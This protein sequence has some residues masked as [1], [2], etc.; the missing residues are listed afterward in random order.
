MQ[1]NSAGRGGRRG[2]ESPI[3]SHDPFKPESPMHAVA[4]ARHHEKATVSL[5]TCPITVSACMRK[6]EVIKDTVISNLTM[7]LGR[8]RVS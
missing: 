5:I 2:N 8:T 1:A 6:K 7:N 4:F 3:V